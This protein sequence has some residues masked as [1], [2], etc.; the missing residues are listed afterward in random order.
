[1]SLAA[2]SLIEL[3][4][5]ESLCGNLTFVE[6]DCHVPFD[7]KR[8]YYVYDIPGGSVRGSHAH[9]RLQQFMVAASG[10]FDV[11]LDDGRSKRTFHLNRAS[12]GLYIAPMCWRE[13][14]NFAT[15]SLCLV[16]AS[17]HYD[18]NDYIR[19]YS[20]FLQYTQNPSQPMLRHTGK[21]GAC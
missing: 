11:E 10:S 1:M 3:P 18:E 20:E 16:L 12:C 13:L 9:K 19:D 17:A 6:G 21:T 15:G 4:K 8:V 5:V 7:I 14:N 2:C